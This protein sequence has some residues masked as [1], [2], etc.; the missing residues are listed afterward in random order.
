MKANR[1]RD[2]KPEI[3]IRRALHSKGLRYRIDFPLRFED[4]RVR[5]D[6]V[7][8]RRR[9]A[10]FV[11]GCFWHGCPQHY[12][13]PRS[14]AEFWAEKIHHN[15]DRDLRDTAA[16]AQHGWTVVRIWEHEEV[17]DAVAAIL[18]ALGSTGADR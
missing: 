16:L 4:S 11:D 2:T 9:V 8:T 1:R 13:P 18:R 14:N 10:V 3:L 12:I 17:P 7:F 15:V 5:P 6:I